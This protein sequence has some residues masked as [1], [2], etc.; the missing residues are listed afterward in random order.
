MN[1]KI[2]DDIHG[3][4]YPGDT[5]MDDIH[6]I[7]YRRDTSMGES[8]TFVSAYTNVHCIGTYNSIALTH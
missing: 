4:I 5:S 8:D 2:F 6:S 1:P 3:I 7:I